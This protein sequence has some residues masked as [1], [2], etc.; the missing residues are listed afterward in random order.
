VNAIGIAE[1]R[2]LNEKADK[3]RKK[4]QQATGGAL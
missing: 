2:G 3:L 4:F 1:E